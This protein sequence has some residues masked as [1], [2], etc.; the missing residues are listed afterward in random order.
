MTYLDSKLQGFD[1]NLAWKQ[2]CKWIRKIGTPFLELLYPRRC[3]FCHEIVSRQG[4]LICPDCEEIVKQY[5]L[6][7]QVA[8]A[9]CGKS[10][11]DPVQE[12]C[13]D[14]RRHQKSF[15][16]GISVFR[17]GRR[18]VP[19][20]KGRKPGYERNY[21]GESMLKFKY[22]NAREYGDY[23]IDTMMK[24]YGD[25]IRNWRPEVIIPVPVHPS[26]LKQRGYNQ[27][28]VLARKLSD[29]TGIPVRT[30]LLVR[31]I[32]TAPQKKLSDAERLKNLR[33]AFQVRKPI[34]KGSR[35]IL[36]IDDIYT[37]GSTMEACT[38]CLLEQGAEKVFVASICSGQ[39]S[40]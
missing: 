36:L 10:I 23:Y 16:A 35:R 8:C 27:A 5:Y 39:S 15:S 28:E 2:T 29:R 1:W 37:T 19:K 13:E 30:D 22:Y 31:R 34:P 38:R 6:I 26:R 4:T 12:Y 33:Q 32:R 7:G 14:C 17:Y 24:E 21:F 11:P 40:D 20:P 18:N 3:P 9:R 25:I